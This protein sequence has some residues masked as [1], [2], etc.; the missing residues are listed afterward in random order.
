M[1]RFARYNKYVRASNEWD[2]IKYLVIHD[3][4]IVFEE[5]YEFD[6]ETAVNA[7]ASIGRNGYKATKGIEALDVLI[8]VAKTEQVVRAADARIKIAKELGYKASELNES[9]FR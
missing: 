8:G 9:R 4:S 6:L 2:R 5:D 7:L 1:S 3:H